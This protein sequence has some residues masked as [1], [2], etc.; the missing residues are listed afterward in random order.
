[1]VATTSGP[2]VAMS[3]ALVLTNGAIASLGRRQYVGRS[4]G[5]II[6]KFE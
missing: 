2:T 4:V 6:V 1:M 3:L 5:C